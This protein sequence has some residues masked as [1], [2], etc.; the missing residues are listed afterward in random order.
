[1][2]AF[3]TSYDVARDGRFIFLMPRPSAAAPRAPQVV[4]VENWLADLRTRLGQ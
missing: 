2:D 4:R 1:M 3:Q